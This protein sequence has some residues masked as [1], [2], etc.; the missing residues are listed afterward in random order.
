MRQRRLRRDRRRR[1]TARRQDADR[2]PQAAGVL[3]ARRSERAITAGWMLCSRSPRARTRAGERSPSPRPCAS[4]A[5]ATRRSGLHALAVDR[6]RRRR[7]TAVAVA[8]AG[9]QARA[10]RRRVRGLRRRARL[11]APARGAVGDSADER[12]IGSGRRR[13]H[14]AHRAGQ[15]PPDLRARLRARRERPTACRRSPTSAARTARA[16][17]GWPARS[18]ARPAGSRGS[19][20]RTSHCR[21]GRCATCSAISPIHRRQPALA[22]ARRRRPSTTTRTSASRRPSTSAGSRASR[23]PPRARVVPEPGACGH[24]AELPCRP[25]RRRR[26]VLPRL[27][28]R[29]ARSMTSRR[30]CSAAPTGRWLR[31]EAFR[32]A[33]ERVRVSFVI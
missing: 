17:C 27:R 32:R 14:A 1:A 30:C 8:A 15:P 18:T 9:A 26:L 7:A 10:P 3:P 5:P 6:R 19:C 22:E 24:D 33:R 21:R 23:C 13:G 25:R 31:G 29:R 2:H 11:L 28:H 16:S 12:R 4:S 20:G